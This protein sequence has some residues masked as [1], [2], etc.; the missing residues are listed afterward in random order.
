MHCLAFFHAFHALLVLYTFLLLNNKTSL[1][2]KLTW[3]EF[4]SICQE[5]KP[6]NIK[7]PDWDKVET[8]VVTKLSVHQ[9]DLLHARMVELK[10]TATRKSKGSAQRDAPCKDIVIDSEDFI[11]ASSVPEVLRKKPKKSLDQ[12]GEKQLKARTDEIWTKVEE[13]AE[14]NDETPMRILALLLRKCKER[15]AR[16]FGDSLWQRPASASTPKPSTS[17]TIPIDAAIA[18]MVDCQLVRDT[19]TKL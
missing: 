10:S 17:S 13:Y 9:D 19:Y 2:M 11:S 15:G 3:D 1:T 7:P 14:K 4:F 8:V 18:I 6:N 12:S 16:E 5:A